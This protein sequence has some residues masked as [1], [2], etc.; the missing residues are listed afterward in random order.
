M[1][2]FGSA[3][4]GVPE[5]LGHLLLWLSAS[6]VPVAMCEVVGKPLLLSKPQ[7][8][9]GQQGDKNGILPVRMKQ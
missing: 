5:C 6:T 7:G 8:P 9:H 1:P 3:S 2:H 4:G